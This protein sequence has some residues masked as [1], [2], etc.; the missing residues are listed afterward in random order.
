M[1][2]YYGKRLRGASKYKL[3]IFVHAVYQIRTLL[4]IF[5]HST[6]VIVVLYLTLK[7]YY[8]LKGIIFV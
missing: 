8:N 2:S 4:N 5:T 1:T 7:Q 3:F 6:L